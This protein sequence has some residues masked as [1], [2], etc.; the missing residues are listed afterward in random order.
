MIVAPLNEVNA[1]LMVRGNII[2]YIT[3]S[4]LIDAFEVFIFIF[5]FNV[6]ILFVKIQPY[7]KIK[8]V[9]LVKNKQNGM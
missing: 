1:S 5:I 6:S 7:A 4:H 3:E 2:Q 8:D 9:R